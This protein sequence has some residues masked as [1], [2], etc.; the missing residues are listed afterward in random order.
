MVGQSQNAL[1]YLIASKILITN[2]NMVKAICLMVA[3]GKVL[4]QHIG[5]LAAL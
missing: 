2:S 3:L 1:G 5:S 4:G